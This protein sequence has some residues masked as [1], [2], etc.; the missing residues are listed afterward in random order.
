MG[1]GKC[2]PFFEAGHLHAAIDV[3]SRV[4]RRQ[5]RAAEVRPL[6]D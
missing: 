2:P 3:A 1:I 6:V 4:H 5:G